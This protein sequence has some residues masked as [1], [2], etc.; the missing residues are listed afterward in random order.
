MPNF[1]AREYY[2]PLD[3][4]GD[5]RKDRYNDNIYTYE[6]GLQTGGPRPPCGFNFCP[7]GFIGYF[8]DYNPRQV[9][10]YKLDSSKIGVVS[11]LREDLAINALPTLSVTST[12]TPNLPVY[13]ESTNQFRWGIDGSGNYTDN[14]N[15]KIGYALSGRVVQVTAD[16][17]NNLN[18]RVLYFP[19]VISKNGF[20]AIF[21]A[22]GQVK[23]TEDSF[24]S[25]Y[26]MNGSGSANR[27]FAAQGDFG[28]FGRATTGGNGGNSNTNTGSL[29]GQSGGTVGGANG[30][31]NNPNDLLGNVPGRVVTPGAGNTTGLPGAVGAGGEDAAPPVRLQEDLVVIDHSSPLLADV[32]LGR[33]PAADADLGRSGA[34]GGASA[35]V[36]QRRYRLAT[37]ANA[38]VCAPNDVESQA[39]GTDARQCKPAK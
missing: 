18:S 10:G 2:Y 36:F 20:E 29:G 25:P 14:A 13:D 22:S 32:L 21:N 37:S 3:S 35:S 23:G 34:G 7:L 17:L 6:G 30:N 1:V 39:A 12:V 5:P 19:G 11:R 16:D 31:S 4:N 24:P 26:L 33:R 9:I 8:L 27:G 15:G 28:I 38:A